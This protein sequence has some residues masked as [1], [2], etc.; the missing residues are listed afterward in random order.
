MQPNATLIF[1]S[2]LRRNREAARFFD[3]CTPG[4]KEAILSQLDKVE[5]RTPLPA[6]SPAPPCNPGGAV[7]CPEL[8]G[9]SQGN[10]PAHQEDMFCK[11]I[12]SFSN[13]KC[14]ISATT[15]DFPVFRSII[16]LNLFI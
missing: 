16:F 10:P 14:R 6:I 13:Q 1:Q 9:Y 7:P 5:H 12:L 4:Q 11:E 3:A 8:G 15:S 2:C